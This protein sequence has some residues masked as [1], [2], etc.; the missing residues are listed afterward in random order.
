MDFNK[1]WEKA[2]YKEDLM[3][4]FFKFN[5][6]IEY[7]KVLDIDISAIF[8]N[9]KLVLLMPMEV[10]PTPLGNLCWRP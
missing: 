3:F 8:P 2:K 5:Y 9:D 7:S 10:M 6:A 1:G 4:G